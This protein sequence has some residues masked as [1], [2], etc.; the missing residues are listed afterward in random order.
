MVLPTNI[1]HK[2]SNTASQILLELH[3]QVTL[4]QC[5]GTL[6]HNIGTW[7]SSETGDILLRNTIAKYRKKV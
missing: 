4:I 3:S 6:L 5:T 2:V 1:E 7:G